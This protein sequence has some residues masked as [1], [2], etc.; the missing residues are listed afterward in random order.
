MT[1]KLATAPYSQ[2]RRPRIFGAAVAFILFSFIFATLM[3]IGGVIFREG[4]PPNLETL[5]T[6]LTLFLSP[7]WMHWGPQYFPFSWALWKGFSMFAGVVIGLAFAWRAGKPLIV[8]RQSSGR[9]LLK[10]RAALKQIAREAAAEIGKYKPG[11]N[12]HSAY[13]LSMGRETQGIV[14]MGSQGS[15]KTQILLP[16]MDS[17]MKDPAARSFI[18]D[19]KGDFT[20]Y[21]LDPK[22]KDVAL[23]APWDSRSASWDISS[24]IHSQ[25]D[26]R[27]L[28]RVLTGADQATGESQSWASG[29]AQ[30]LSA[31]IVTLHRNNPKWRWSDLL[32]VLGLP[33]EM[34][35]Q[36]AL[37]ADPSCSMML[38]EGNKADKTTQ[39]YLSRLGSMVAPQVSDFARAERPNARR[40]SFRGWMVGDKD[41]PRVIICSNSTTYKSM[42]RNALQAAMR[43]AASALDT[44][45]ESKKTKRW[46]FLDEMPRMGPQ[47]Y[48]AELLAVGRSKGVRVV[49]AAQDIAQVRKELG[50]EDAQSIL[51][52]CGTHIYLKTQGGETP[53]WL[54]EQVGE[55]TVWRRIKSSSRQ[56]GGPSST[57]ENW[58]Q[59]P[60]KVIRPEEFGS[61]Y[62]GSIM[63]IGPFE[64]KNS[65]LVRFAGFA[66]VR[67]YLLTGSNF[68]YLLSWPKSEISEIA[69]QR[70]PAA[71]TKELARAGAELMPAA[72]DSPSP[73]PRGGGAGGAGGGALAVQEQGQEAAPTPAVPDPVDWDF[74]K[75]Q[76][77]TA[78][79]AVQDE[80]EVQRPDEEDS[81]PGDA[82]D[83]VA[84]EA[85]EAALDAVMPGVGAVV[86]VADLFNKIMSPVP[87]PA[88]GQPQSGAPTT[89]TAVAIRFKKKEKGKAEAEVIEDDDE[90]DEGTTK[91]KGEGE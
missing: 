7:R 22:N 25:A 21:F 90:D 49:L 50:K 47:P 48:I 33:Y 30:I 35:R 80:D 72:F 67:G 61:D 43:A 82:G 32:E 74:L 68:V 38:N 28:S 70:K 2:S 29:S 52:G 66:G 4:R 27:E 37:Q 36:T 62:I 17:A 79:P 14:L 53:G 23:F 12:L 41:Q 76:A 83:G 63:K 44:M 65:W 5:I 11:L 85:G 91:G 58:V 39:S 13:P 59:S 34:L 40:I 77:A 26:A 10:G 9:I 8:E 57:S 18:H 81:G 1:T 46:F 69:A 20:S 89:A 31:L 60:E 45:P 42:A 87:P 73:E 71:W 78:V 56:A 15:G 55:K 3:W 19:F 6:Y 75:P 64:V 51:S 16:I 84:A 88:E 54:S 86:K 24:D